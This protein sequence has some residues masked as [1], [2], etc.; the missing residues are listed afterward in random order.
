MNKLILIALVVVLVGCNS[1]TAHRWATHDPA[2]K[3]W[4]NDNNGGPEAYKDGP[5]CPDEKKDE[6]P[7]APTQTNRPQTDHQKT[8]LARVFF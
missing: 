6:R 8:P 5:G 4:H 7:V 3:L 2:Q 1:D